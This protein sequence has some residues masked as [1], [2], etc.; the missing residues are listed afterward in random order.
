MK[1]LLLYFILVVMSLTIS[2]AKNTDKRLSF[3]FKPDKTK[4]AG[5]ALIDYFLDN[6]IK[7][8]LKAYNPGENGPTRE[9]IRQKY[10]NDEI[11]T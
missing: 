9:S 7:N 6:G 4:R 5:Y 3:T 2:N 8:R 11:I 1:Q 10:I